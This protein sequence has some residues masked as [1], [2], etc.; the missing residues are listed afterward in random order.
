MFS[1]PLSVSFNVFQAL[2]APEIK[3]SLCKTV[4]KK[5]YSCRVDSHLDKPFLPST[6]H[7]ILIFLEGKQK[8][9]SIFTKYCLPCFKDSMLL[10]TATKALIYS[11]LNLILVSGL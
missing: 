9:T 10:I 4:K 11:C 2:I 8:L 1:E 5:S 6:D 7:F 3:E